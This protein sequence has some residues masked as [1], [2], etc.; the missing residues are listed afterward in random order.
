MEGMSERMSVMDKHLL[1]QPLPGVRGE[2]QESRKTVPLVL[3]ML[4]TVIQEIATI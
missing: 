2:W 4:F 1:G 3:G